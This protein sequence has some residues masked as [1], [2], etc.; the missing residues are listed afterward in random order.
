MQKKQSVTDGP[1]DWR[2]DG[3]T[4]RDKNSHRSQSAF[5]KSDSELAV[6]GFCNHHQ[7]LEKDGHI[8]QKMKFVAKM[9]KREIEEKSDEQK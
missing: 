6:G 4:D 3:P 5:M 7:A 2:T 1:T 8:V 9:N